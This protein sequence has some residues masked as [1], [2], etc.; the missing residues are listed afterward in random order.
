MLIP[1]QRPSSLLPDHLSFSSCQLLCHTEQPIPV[2]LI[3]NGISHVKLNLFAFAKTQGLRQGPTWL[4][5]PGRG[6]VII[7]PSPMKPS[8]SGEAAPHLNLA[9]VNI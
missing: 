8:L 6:W 3:S 7:N 5:L 2:Q 1:R 9:K 4:M